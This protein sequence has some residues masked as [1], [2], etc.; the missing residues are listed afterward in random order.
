MLTNG[1]VICHEFLAK[2]IH[3]FIFKGFFFIIYNIFCPMLIIMQNV[4]VQ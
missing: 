2:A 4:A 3:N 1:F